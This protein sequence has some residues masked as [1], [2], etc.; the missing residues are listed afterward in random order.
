MVTTKTRLMKYENKIINNM[1]AMLLADTRQ[2]D[3]YRNKK[4]RFLRDN[5]N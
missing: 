5:S 1:Q 4:M 3:M 2:F